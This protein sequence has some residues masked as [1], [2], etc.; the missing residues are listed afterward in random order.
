MIDRADIVQLVRSFVGLSADNDPAGD[1]GRLVDFP[2]GAPPEEELKIRTNCAMF[3]C[4]IWRELG[5][6]D[7]LLHHEYVNGQALTWALEIAR[8]RH[9]IFYPHDGRCPQIGDVLYFATPPKPGVKPKNDDHLTFVVDGP[10]DFRRILRAG[11]GGAHN[12]IS[13]SAK[14]STYLWDVERPL[15]G[16]IDTQLVVG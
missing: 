10:D 2:G 6:S 7:P 15:R 8:N 5:C 14:R 1:L 4:G 11:G 16:F 9:A 3:V 13:E 12:L